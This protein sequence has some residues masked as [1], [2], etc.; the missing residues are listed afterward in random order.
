MTLREIKTTLQNLAN[1][2][3]AEIAQ[4]FFK[5][6]AG[7]YGEGDRFLGVKVPELR[8]LSRKNKDL[9]LADTVKLLKSKY[10][11]ERQLA[12][13]ILALKFPSATESEQSKIY[14]LYLK[15][16]RHINNWDLVDCSAEHIIGAYLRERSKKQLHD[17]A[18]S[19]DLW[20]RRIAILATYHYIK[21]NDYAETLKI[22]GALVADKEDLIHKAVGWMLREVGNRDLAE[23]EGFLK[24]HYR[25][26][27]RTMLRY[28]IE[29]F[30]ES[31][32]QRYLKGEIRARNAE[33]G[34]RN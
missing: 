26:M 30:P 13:F 33:R 12:L 10:H 23:E 25:R 19:E 8:R 34:A 27:P 18:K 9:P 11:E 31:K 17:L 4:R 2:K 16:T 6:G 15:N 1:K 21:Q 7:E 3:Q 29:K 14:E 5:T 22:S 24:K 20:E 28:A 32:R